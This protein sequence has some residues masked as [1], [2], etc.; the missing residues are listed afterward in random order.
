MYYSS[1]KNINYSANSNLFNETNISENSKLISAFN[2]F[3]SSF[4]FKCSKTLL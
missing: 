4:K 2:Y 3:S 1:A